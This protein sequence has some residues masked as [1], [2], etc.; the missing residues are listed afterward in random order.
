VSKETGESFI[1]SGRRAPSLLQYAVERS[2]PMSAW[3]IEHTGDTQEPAVVRISR[4][5]GGPYKVSLKIELKIL[6]SQFVLTY[7]LRDGDPTVYLHL[8]GTWFQRG[9]QDAGTP[10]LRLAV[11]CTL[12]NP[13]PLYEIPF[14]A[15]A[16][17]MGHGEEVPALRWAAIGGAIGGNPRGLLLLND[18]KHGHAFVGDTLYLTLIRASFAP[19]PLPEIGR[20]EVHLG[21]RP[22]GAQPEVAAA[23][24]RARELEHPIRVVSTDAHEGDLPGCKSLLHWTSERSV[25]CAIKKAEDGEGLIIRAYN[26]SDREDEVRIALDAEG[27][28]TI[29][30]AVEVDLLERN[31]PD[32]RIKIE[33]GKAFATIA[34]RGI[35]SVRLGTQGAWGECAS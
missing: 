34:P 10:V 20:H 13:V 8:E 31:V 35:W 3:E 15:I 24:R 32:G 30:S 4:G 27:A 22:L 25:L 19:D 16:R 11:P 12:E 7:E 14:G 5:H 6:E 28:G 17:D 2:R 21:L 9:G 18:C 1:H 29:V 33:A 26:P 23:T